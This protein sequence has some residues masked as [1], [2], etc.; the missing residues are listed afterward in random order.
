SEARGPDM[1]GLR[2]ESSDIV[3]EFQG[4][5]LV[6][7]SELQ[8][9]GTHNLL[10]VQAALALIYSVGV[11]P[12]EVIDALKQFKGLPHRC[13]L[14]GDYNQVTW[15]NDSKATNIGAAEAAIFGMRPLV[16]G[17]LILIAG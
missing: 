7:A 13:E 17:K 10:N 4:E 2:Q 12:S 16:T 3:L 5:P 9:T 11:H 14:I 15:V 1:F 8:T 6:R